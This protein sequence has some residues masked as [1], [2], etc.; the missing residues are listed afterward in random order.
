[1]CLLAGSWRSF[2]CS[3]LGGYWGSQRPWQCCHCGTCGSWLWTITGRWNQTWWLPLQP[4]W[5]GFDVY[6]GSTIAWEESLGT[7]HVYSWRQVQ[8]PVLLLC[9]CFQAQVSLYYLYRGL[10][11][12]RFSAGQK[13]GRRDFF[14]PL[15]TWCQD[16][17]D[18][19]RQK[20][21]GT[22]ASE[23]DWGRSSGKAGGIW[24]HVIRN[25]GKWQCRHSVL[26]NKC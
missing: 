25:T 23:K 20:Q 16:A 22:G 1:M 13:K 2:T 6:A 8:L 14:W 4:V 10:D 18:P 17:W 24:P 7:G 21:D 26:V 9:L 5:P 11:S 12:I 19:N 15:R 3:F